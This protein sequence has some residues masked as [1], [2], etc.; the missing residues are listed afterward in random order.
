MN[1]ETTPFDHVYFNSEKHYLA[2]KEYVR[3]NVNV[4]NKITFKV[5]S[6]HAVYQTGQSYYHKD[7]SAPR[8]ALELSDES[9]ASLVILNGYYE[10]Y[11]ESLNEEELEFELERLAEWGLLLENKDELLAVYDCLMENN[12]KVG[13]AS[14]YVEDDEVI[15]INHEVN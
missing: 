10:E 14:D 13:N 5:E 6:F 15:L 2:N 12:S 9:D 1:I 4:Y 7:I 3:H 8:Q 11:L